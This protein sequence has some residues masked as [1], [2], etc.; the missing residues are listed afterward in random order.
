MSSP[1]SSVGPRS[2]R[3]VLLAL[4]AFLSVLTA[5]AAIPV[6]PASAQDDIS[7]TTPPITITPGFTGAERIET[8]VGTGVAGNIDDDPAT[9]LGS[10]VNSVRGVAFSP[11]GALHYVELANHRVRRVEADGT[12]T[13]IIGNGVVGFVLPDPPLASATQLNI[14]TDIGFDAAGNLYVADALNHRILRVNTDGMVEVVAGTGVAG[15]VE[16]DPPIATTSQIAIPFGLEV[17][18]DGTFFFSELFGHRVRRVDPDGSIVTMAGTGIQGSLVA[19]PPVATA[20]ELNNPAGLVMSE[21][22]TLFIA[23]Y[24]GQRIVAAEPDGSIRVVAG[25]GTQG[26]AEDNPPTALGSDLDNPSSVDVDSFG[27]VYVTEQ[28]NHRIRRIHPDGSITTIAGTNVAGSQDDATSTAAGSQLSSPWQARLA[29]NGDLIIVDDIN[30]RIR[31]VIADRAAPTIDVAAEQIV[32]FDSGTAAFDFT[33]ADPEATVE[34]SS[35]GLAEC[36][37]AIDGA[38]VQTGHTIDTTTAG[39]VELVIT[40]TDNAGNVTVATATIIVNEAPPVVEE[41]PEP[42]PFRPADDQILRLYQAAFG[43]APDA[44]GFAF[45]ARAY[46]EGASLGAIATQFLASPES[47]EV[48]GASPTNEELLDTVYV[49]VLGRPGDEGGRAFW[50]SQLATGMTRTELL[51]AFAD[52]PEN[53]ERTGTAP[54]L[55]TGESQ[56]LRLYQAALGRTPDAGGLAF[57]VNRLSSGATLDVIAGQL[58]LSPESIALYGE[59]PSDAAFIDALYRNVLGRPADT[60]GAGF[61]LDR[62][63]TGT[64][65]D[66]VIVAFSESPE[67]LERTGTAA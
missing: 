3:S 28:R 8:I 50:L 26:L 49:N 34:S 52:S 37:A 40:A 39:T 31:R 57:W 60:A 14:P 10:Q 62:L 17:L 61:W 59:Q 36:H 30:A 5:T 41:E 65:R 51:L 29:P 21:T 7:D 63:A 45:W 12:L 11:D 19:D 2:V 22:G 58:R 35:T 24:V 23:D 44:D 18:A 43:R 46:R 27:N 33:C 48:Y 55:T 20:S 54:P 15:S 64:S 16:S 9:A 66:A 32:E 42:R 38:R 4:A 67:N 47:I 25:T 13:D 56:V 1:T 53:I 6:S